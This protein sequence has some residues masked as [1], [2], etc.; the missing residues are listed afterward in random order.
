MVKQ[1]NLI[2]TLLLFLSLSL[3]ASV[4]ATA[5]PKRVEVGE[6]VTYSLHISGKD[7]TR[8]NI[9]K[10]CDSDIISTNT[11]TN[12]Q[13]ING[14]LSQSF[15][16]S[17]RFV[18][19]K[20]CKI[21]PVEVEVDGNLESGNEVEIEVVP[22]SMTKESDF[23]LTISSE[24]KE[25]FVGEPFEVTLAFKQR[26]DAEALDS[27]FTP[28]DFSGFWI[29][30]ESKPQREEE[31]KFV[32]TKIIYT[33]MPQRTG[34]FTLSKAQMQIASRSSSA[35]SWGAWIPT[36]KW[37]SYFSNEL[38]FHIKPL[39]QGIN[40]VGDF[41]IDV[42]ADKSEA[43]A[44]EAV[45]VAIEVKGSGNLEDIKSFKPLIQGVG[46][47]DEKIFID[48]SKLTQKIAFVSER[49]FIIPSF[50][51][52]Y[53]DI[54]TKEIK[55][56]QTKEI[57]IKI[58]NAKPKESLNIQREASQEPQSKESQEI[59]NDTF[60]LFVSFLLGVV[61][62]MSIMFFIKRVSFKK[63]PKISVKDPKALLMQLLPF[64]EEKDVKEIIDI[65][66]KNIYENQNIAIDKKVLKEVLSRYV[67]GYK[68]P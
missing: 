40:L 50:S 18:P 31:G 35:D 56:I 59:K 44:N 27:K 12:M 45:N 10:L 23:A 66:E 36:I 38:S 26:R 1:K 39:P 19:Q 24:K 8:P 54:K 41:T 2:G 28:P 49:D 33:L 63:E 58:K 48:G 20:S 46:V 51:L 13:I 61:T 68:R 57:A 4:R 62:T 42:S 16:I 67:Q 14:V 32:I 55:S 30:S 43:E 47:F 6:S 65:L 53:F 15:M 7:V 37:R 17:Y 3:D 9:T 52:K 22:Q 64:K 60:V 5:E 11:Q 25:F 21:A 34:D 29:K